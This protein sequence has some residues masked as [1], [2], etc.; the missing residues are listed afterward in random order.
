VGTSYVENQRSYEA[1]T[2]A[3]DT[4][5]EID[6]KTLTLSFQN[7]TATPLFRLHRPQLLRPPKPPVLPP[8]QLLRPPSSFTT[9][10]QTKRPA[11]IGF[12]LRRRPPAMDPVAVGCYLAAP[13]L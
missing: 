5:S 9:K 6:L 1:K 11:P 8:P 10:F 7:L 12:A 4:N 13:Q 2:D 3:T